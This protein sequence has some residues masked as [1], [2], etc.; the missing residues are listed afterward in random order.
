MASPASVVI[1]AS[2]KFFSVWYEFLDVY[3]NLLLE[4]LVNK[5]LSGF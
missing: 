3:N 4:C 1:M 5:T 2:K